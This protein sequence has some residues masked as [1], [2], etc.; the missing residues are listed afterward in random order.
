MGG[1][2]TGGQPASPLDSLAGLAGPLAGL[3]AQLA[4]ERDEPAKHDS[5]SGEAKTD[6]AADAAK[7]RKGGDS[8]PAGQQPAPS[9]TPEQASPPV[10]PPPIAPPPSTAV[11]LPD[12]STATARSPEVAAAVKAYLAGAPLDAAYR[13]AGIDLPPPGTPVTNPLDPSA[14]TAGAIGMFRDH[15]VVALSPAKALQDGQVVSLSSAASGPD[16]LGWMDPSPVA[17]PGPSPTTPP[18][19]VPAG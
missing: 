5:A 17:V 9:A 6:A 13:Q 10:G 14:L 11:Q 3:S 16:F 18:A 15:Y 12:G 1:F 2:P 7:N 4:G 8:A 19:L